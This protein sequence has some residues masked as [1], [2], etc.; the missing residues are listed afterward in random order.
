M[1]KRYIII[2]IL[3]IGSAFGLI[4]IPKQ[5]PTDQIKPTAFLIEINDPARFLETDQIAKRLIEEDP[6]LFLIDVRSLYEYEDYSIPAS[7]NIPLEE[8]L[9][10]QW[11]DF[12]DQE[13]M[14]IV[15]YSNGDVYADQAWVLTA[16]T[17][18]SNLYVM[19]GG[20]NEWFRT[21]MKPE[22]PGEM[23]P[24]EAYDLYSFRKGASIF[25]GGSA[26]DVPLLNENEGAPKKKKVIVKKKV[27]KAAEGGC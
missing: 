13:G 17:G 3:L 12:I 24:S 16:Q 19:K 25:F 18:R 21:I 2:A 27:K 23:D 4:L 1:S 20:L 7:V 8:L 10:E 26:Q 5:A 22:K 6:T 11:S 9:L 15:F 14:D